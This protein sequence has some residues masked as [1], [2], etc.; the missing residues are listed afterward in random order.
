MRGKSARRRR[1]RR[2]GAALALAAACAACA[3]AVPALGAQGSRFRPATRSDGAIVATESPAASRAARS[4]LNHGGNA[5]DAAVTATFALGAARPQSCGIG[6]G[7]FLVYRSAG[8]RTAAL[9]FRETAPAAVTA[10]T[11]TG[12]GPHKDFTGWRTVGVPG[13]LAGMAAALDRFGTLSLAETIAPAERLA[14]NGFNVPPSLA[15]DMKSNASRL[16]NF[17]AAAHQYLVNGTDPYAP[18]ARLVQPQLARTLRAIANRGPDVFYRGSLAREIAAAAQSAPQQLAGDEGLI[19]AADFDRYR[20]RWRTPLEGTYRGRQ[21]IAMPPPT[22]GGTAIIEMLNL[23][24]GYDL[25]AMG[26]SSADAL[27]VLAEAQKLAWADRNAYL[28]DPDFLRVP[29][30]TLTSKSYANRRR[31][32]ISMERA[33]SYQPGDVSDAT[34]RAAGRDFNAHGS[35][36]HVAIIDSQGNAVSLT[37]TIEQSFGSAVLAPGGFLLNNELT[38]FSDPGT[39]NEPAPGK[40]PRSSM[41]PTIVAYQGRPVLAVG[42]AGGARIIEGTLLPIVDTIDF[43]QDVAQAVDAERIDD[44]TGTLTIEDARVAPAVLAELS[45]RGHRLAPKGEYDIT[46]RVQAAGIDPVTGERVGVSD[47]RTEF[48]ALAA[49]PAAVQPTRPPPV[50]AQDP[51]VHFRPLL[52]NLG[53][54]RYLLRWRARDRGGSGIASYAV[55]IGLGDPRTGLFQTVPRT[56]NTP[57]LAVRLRRGRRYFFR[58]KAIDRAGNVSRFARLQVRVP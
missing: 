24:E 34:A 37:C 20:A 21:V 35:T 30:G 23:L 46:P 51:Q 36:T 25:A 32:E 12:P 14:R 26:Q 50:D 43:G 15:A 27:H 55:G 54:G 3:L 33:G 56:A 18:G 58:V 7:G 49:G 52:L 29:V 8:G 4:V 48:A 2:A 47:P 39:A 41:S 53:H 31:G 45:R 28:A 6:G 17:P 16:Q 11:F 9:D 40:R 10:T 44:P 22:S 57:Q 42:G 13:V 5:M 19:T 38:D 1:I